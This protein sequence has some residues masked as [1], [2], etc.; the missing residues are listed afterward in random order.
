MKVF[1]WL[2]LFITLFQDVSAFDEKIVNG[3]TPLPPHPALYNTVALVK[4]DGSIYCTGAI[5]G[6]KLVVT[7]KHCLMNRDPEDVNI[8]FGSST[9]KQGVIYQATDYQVRYPTDWMMM[10][11]NFDIAWVKFAEDL[12]EGY[13]PLPI[14]ADRRLL[15]EGMNIYQAGF[16]NHSPTRGRVEAGERL[17]GMT[18]LG[19]FFN[20]PR[21]YNI[22]LFQRDPGQG[23]CHADSGGPAYARIHSKW[24]I[25]GATNGFDVVLTPDAMHRTGDPDFPYNVDCAKNQSLYNFVGAHG[26]WIEKTSKAEVWKSSNFL[27]LDREPSTDSINLMSWCKARDFGSPSWNL[28]KILIDKKVDQ[29]PQD[30]GRSFYN[31]CN[32]VVDYLKSIRSIYL[33]YNS[34][35]EAHINFSAARLLPQLERISI[36]EYPVDHI[37]FK[38]IEHLHLKELKLINLG[39]SDLEFG[40]DL[41]IEALFLDKNPLTNIK[42]IRKI[43][44]LKTLSLTGT[45]LRTID[46]L[47]GIPLQDLQ[48]VGMNTSILLGLDSVTPKLESLDLR[49]TYIPDTDVLRNFT[50]LKNFKATGIS[51]KIDLSENQKIETLEL[52]EFKNGEVTFPRALPMLKNLRFT[53]SDVDSIDFLKGSPLVEELSL[54]FNR[55]QDL[56]VFK[57]YPFKN[58]TSINLSVNPILDLS[59]LVDLDALMILRVFRTPIQT[60]LVPKTEENCPTDLGALVLRKFCSK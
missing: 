19:H 11:P 1:L 48:L 60:N 29:M 32:Q 18:R 45:T 5:I 26:R 8:F 33:N 28:L 36:Y 54:T 12:P 27:E 3:V 2:T 22:L 42:G 21:F 40:P 41:T 46:A 15:K 52:N 38:S 6:P 35:P 17:V 44:G 9:H 20:N 14:L 7:A 53:R 31:D 13:H 39:L 25:V 4:S 43:K 57:K 30:Q 55:I 56:R 34:T 24:Y 37:N 23:S 49:D 58:L 51:G 10:F 59:P 16:G 50:E 47:K